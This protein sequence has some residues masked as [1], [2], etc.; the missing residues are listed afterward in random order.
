MKL[1]AKKVSK[2][3]GIEVRGVL[4][5]DVIN[6]FDW[7]FDIP[8][9]VVTVSIGAI[10]RNLFSRKAETIPL[11]LLNG[12]PVLHTH[13]QNKDIKAFLDTG[14][15][16]S[17]LE[18]SL[19]ARFPREKVVED[20][21]PLTGPFMTMLHR[22]RIVFSSAAEYLDCGRLPEKLAPLLS[23]AG[24]QG[25]IGSEIL[26]HRMVLYSP[27]QKLLV[28]EVPERNPNSNSGVEIEEKKAA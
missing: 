1:T 18:P 10:S 8:N 13:V 24:A 21:H 23:M 19:L 28:L 12:I 15:Q 4:G 26:L 11:N 17:Y 5:T 14:A 2:L 20:F 25:I 9:Q 16:F 6:Q 22:V 27:S 7:L 3:G